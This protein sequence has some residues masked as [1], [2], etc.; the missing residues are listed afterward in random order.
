MILPQPL[1]CACE[2]H[3]DP[4]C[5]HRPPQS[6]LN[7]DPR[8]VSVPSSSAV[9]PS[10][11]EKALET[12]ENCGPS[13]SKDCYKITKD[14]TSQQTTKL[15]LT[16]ETLADKLRLVSIS[17]N[18]SAIPE[19][20]DQIPNKQPKDHLLEI[21]K[22]VSSFCEEQCNYFEAFLQNTSTHSEH[23]DNDVITIPDSNKNETVWISDP[24]NICYVTELEFRQEVIFR[25]GTDSIE[26]LSGIIEQ[27]Y[28]DVDITRHEQF[29]VAVGVTSNFAHQLIFILNHI[30]KP[31]EVEFLSV[32]EDN[33]GIMSKEIRGCVVSLTTQL[34]SY[35]SVA[36]QV[37]I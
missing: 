12:T 2:S 33:D 20:L 5:S 7:P 25:N 35:I 26:L 4:D 11:I 14:T 17:N 15:E 24:S 1:E 18:N 37:I 23:L 8:E 22:R 10:S 9:I 16:D 30:L 6:E 31:C 19:D 13:T 29:E 36:A 32:L 34:H 27:E 21:L 3:C 28:N